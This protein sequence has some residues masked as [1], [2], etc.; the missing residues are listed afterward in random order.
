[1]NK[2]ITI[3]ALGLTCV[4]GDISYPGLLTWSHTPRIALAGGG[5]ILY[6]AEGDRLNPAVLSYESQRQFHASLI[7][8]P[9]DIRLESFSI[10]FP[11]ERLTKNLSFRHQSF[12]IFDGYDESANE[13][14]KYQSGET[15][16]TGS[17]SKK[18]SNIPIRWG[19]SSSLFYSQLYNYSSLAIA[20]NGGGLL[21]IPRIQSFIGLNVENF[22]IP[23]S[24]YTEYKESLPAQV[25]ISISKTLVHLPL[26]IML[27]VPYSFQ[28]EKLNIILS[29]E[30]KLANGIQIRMG[31]SSQRINQNIQQS[32]SQSAISGTGFGLNYS[33]KDFSIGMGSY[34]YGTGGWVNG[35]EFGGKF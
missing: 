34:F 21:N 20:F 9:A 33:G 27:E 7:Q 25:A 14:G 13:T 16:V 4:F 19:L 3:I 11:S 28:T 32:V 17:I 8:F 12:G 18:I 26:Q 35:I 2:I 10:L 30:F 23:L 5:R 15:M 31:T 1:M 22:G 29:G 24:S 6:G